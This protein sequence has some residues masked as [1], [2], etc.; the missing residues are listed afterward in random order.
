[1]RPLDELLTRNPVF[2][3]F[4]AAGRAQLAQRALRREYAKDEAMAQHGQVWPYLL[5]VAAGSIAGCKESREGRSL[6]VMTL[7]PGDTFWGLAFFREEAPMPVRLEARAPSTLY[8]WSRDLLEPLL[9]QNA[10]ALW[11]LCRLQAG[12]MEW[13]SGMLEGLAFLP[14][15]GR[16]ARLLLSRFER[17]GS[18]RLPRDLTLDEMAAWAG[19]TREMACRTLYRLADQGLIG[20]SRNELTL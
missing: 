2:A 18:D 17:A 13:A 19:T 4:G 5:L 11:E 1:M 7:E 16:L 6:I 15:A 12:R 14:V 9:L 10:P 3:R 8:L 20:L